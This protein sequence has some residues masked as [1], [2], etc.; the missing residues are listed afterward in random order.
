MIMHL[1]GRF[2]ANLDDAFDENEQFFVKHPLDINEPS[3]F[4]PIE[5]KGKYFIAIFRK[6]GQ[7]F[8]A[9]PFI[10]VHGQ[11]E[12]LTLS[13]NGVGP[14]LRV[15]FVQAYDIESI[16]IPCNEHFKGK[17]Q[18]RLKSCAN[19]MCNNIEILQ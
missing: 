9:R 6:D 15:S 2:Y 19:L 17:L 5:Y 1:F 12:P 14:D 7:V 13:L 8:Y 16:E 10:C 18:V 11:E 3:S 4:E